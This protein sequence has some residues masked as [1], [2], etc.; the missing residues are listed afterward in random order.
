MPR[1]ANPSFLWE[2]RSPERAGG[3]ISRPSRLIVSS[4]PEFL[5]LKVGL[6]RLTL[7]HRLMKSMA[8][9]SQTAKV[10]STPAARPKK[11]LKQLFEER[12]RTQ[13]GSGEEER[14]AEKILEAIFPDT[15]AD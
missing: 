13:P 8:K 4:A 15:N 11:S 6:E 9:R 10:A 2:I 12:D 14:A 7:Y 3:W 5:N 1:A